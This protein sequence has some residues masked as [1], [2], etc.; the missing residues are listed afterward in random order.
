[1]FSNP[2]NKRILFILPAFYR[3][4]AV[5]L[6]INLSEELVNLNREVEILAINQ[7]SHSHLPNKSV[8]V[9]IPLEEN[10]SPKKNLPTYL[11]QLI[12][13]V[14]RADIVF[15]PWENG[16][17]FTYPS[18]IA[19]IL[20]KP[21]V[22]IVQNNIQKTSI[23]Y[24]SAI[25]HIIRWAYSQSIAV[26]CVS[27]GLKKIVAREL[28]LD[29]NKVISISNGMNLEAIKLKAQQPCSMEFDKNDLP[30]IVA[31]GRLAS[32]KGFDVLIKSHAAVIKKGISHRL[33]II[34]EGAEFTALSELANKLGVSQSVTFSGFVNNPLPILARASLFCLSSRYEGLPLSL[35]EAA[36]LGIP[37]IA[38]DC[39]TGPKE[40]LADG[41]YGDLVAT[42]SV[43]A[44][45]NAI[46]KHFQSPERLIEKAKVSAAKAERLSMRNCAKRYLKLVDN[47]V[48]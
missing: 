10:Q 42:E 17:A 37:T 30:F 3:N 41:L 32:Q 20:G 28:N 4:G 2:V 38:T 40:I 21:T 7:Q 33:I 9:S 48:F 16:P 11:I 36:T 12:K 15:L 13:S 6:V 46:E 14:S 39:P 44:L 22:A 18:L 29:V 19:R 25:A 34:G 27:Q 5:D 24:P 1:M 23:D 45:S 31:I 35:I 26:V 8:R 47:L 43:E